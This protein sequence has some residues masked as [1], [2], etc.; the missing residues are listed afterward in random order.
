MAWTDLTFAFG[1]LLTSTK[2]TQLDANFDALA[3]GESGAPTITA[4]AI[5]GLGMITR[6]NTHITITFSLASTNLNSYTITHNL[7][8]ITRVQVWADIPTNPASYMG[9]PYVHTNNAS[10]TVIA[11]FGTNYNN[12]IFVEY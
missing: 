11:G 8:H 3:A 10:I 12:P 6:A 9:P 2:M 4:S 1:S 7:G 5:G